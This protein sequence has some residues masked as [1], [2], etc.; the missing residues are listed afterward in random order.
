MKRQSGLSLVELM[1]A[2]VLGLIVVAAVIELFIST[3]QLYRTQDVKAR[4]QEDGRY[5]LYHIGE[6]LARAGYRG[7][8]SLMTQK[9]AD[10]EDFDSGETQGARAMQNLLTTDADYFWSMEQP[11]FGHEASGNVWEPAKPGA[12]ND[13]VTGSDILTIRTVGSAYIPILSQQNNYFEVGTDNGLDDCDP[14]LEPNTCSN[15]VM[16]SN[17]DFTTVF[18]V[19]NDPSNGQLHYAAGTGIPGNKNEELVG[20]YGPN[21]WVNTIASHSFYVR[22]NPD[23]VPSLYQKTLDGS[24]QAILEGVEQ[25]QIQYGVD[26]NG[27]LAVDSYENANNVAFWSEVV[28]VRISLV[29]VNLEDDGIDTNL[30]LG[31]GGYFLNGVEVNPDDGRLRRVYTQTIMLKNRSS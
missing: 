18:Q 11:V 9:A 6:L 2:L 24:A 13:A 17:C 4:M 22:N 21:S 23:G 29:M 12:L 1:V 27:D 25:M 10:D 20:I 7:C 8:N 28:S 15:I 3:R 14:A 19:T 31:D 26:T 5:A 30:A 16:V